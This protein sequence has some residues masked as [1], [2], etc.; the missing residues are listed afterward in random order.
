MASQDFSHDDTLAAEA[1]ERLARLR[2]SDQPPPVFWAEFLASLVALA[3]A[4]SAHL[5]RRSEN[6]AEWRRL[7]AY[8]AREPAPAGSAELCPRSPATAG[9]VVAALPGPRWTLVARLAT[10]EAES[11]PVVVLPFADEAEAVAQAAAE[12]VR[13][14]LDTPA[15]YLR[16]RAEA[17]SRRE[18]EAYAS[19]LD[20][21]ALVDREKKFGSAALLVC[22]ELA[23]R[24]RAER[25]SLG[26]LG[27]GELA[28]VVALSGADKFERRSEAVRGLEIAMEE[29]ID[30]DM[31]L[32]HPAP[33]GA[34][35]VTRDHA[36]YAAEVGAP[37]LLSA[38]LRVADRA[39]G[40]L[41]A[42]RREAAFGE[43]EEQALRLQ[44]NHL[45][46][47][48]RDLRERDRPWLVRGKDALRRWAEAWAGPRHTLSKV[49]AVGAA[50]LVLILLAGHWPYKVR[51]PFTLR[52][53]Q[54]VYVT[55]PFDGFVRE[56]PARAGDV[57]AADDVLVRFD[58]RELLLEEAMALADLARFRRET[59][60]ARA[61]NELAE[62][63][64][65]EAQAAQASA[66]LEQV[67]HR[68]ARASVT[69]GFAATVAEG[70]LRERIGAPVRA[71]D[72]LFQVARLD[73]MRVEAQVDERDIHE[74]RVGAR[75]RVAFESRPEEVFYLVVEQIEP[76]ARSTPGGAVFHVRCRFEGEPA[77]WWRPG[78]GGVIK[79]E[80]GWRSFFWI[81]THRTADYLRLRWWF[82]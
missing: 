23:H 27:S 40:V 22:D 54:V 32:I 2:V 10:G 4:R 53:E 7:A 73:R 63:R 52:S 74:V 42:E 30:Q 70:D 3:G 61:A 71:G 44:A 13:W 80:S 35:G 45:A 26:W 76:S 57:V 50:A 60:R 38:P 82:W 19:V 16:H 56:A 34:E 39:V 6:E 41:L 33:D 21:T 69:A 66:R 58:D 8:P 18:A 14:A 9:V 75:A 15:L 25:V 37:Y 72:V 49:C 78:M 36:A 79:I 17:A 46:A 12:R 47:R 59:E 48:L 5:W 65:A 77:E 1:A 43:A 31:E 62:L 67:R 51:A 11:A 81:L 68:L 55:A 20:L 64:I 28:R 29:C 24:L